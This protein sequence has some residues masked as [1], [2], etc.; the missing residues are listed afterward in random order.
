MLEAKT[1]YGYVYGF[2]HFAV[3]PLRYI[4]IIET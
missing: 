2:D 1:V 3:T 4:L